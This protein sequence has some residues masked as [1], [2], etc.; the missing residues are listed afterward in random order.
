[1]D[2]LPKIH[3]EAAKRVSYKI[4]IPNNSNLKSKRYEI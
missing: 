1:M 3:S 4:V 2:S